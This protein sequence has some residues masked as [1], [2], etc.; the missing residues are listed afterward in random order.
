[1]GGEFAWLVEELVA[2]H[3]AIEQRALIVQI[4]LGRL[5]GRARASATVEHT[6]LH[7]PVQVRCRGIVRR[8]LGGGGTRVAVKV[9]HPSAHR[10]VVGQSDLAR[11]DRSSSYLDVPEDRISLARGEQCK[12]GATGDG[13]SV[14]VD[15]G[16][17]GTKPSTVLAHVDRQ[18]VEFTTVAIRAWPR[19]TTRPS[20]AID[21]SGVTIGTEFV[22]KAREGDIAF[23]PSVVESFYVKLEFARQ[24]VLV[25]QKAQFAAA[26]VL[27]MPF[28]GN[29]ERLQW[30]CVSC[31]RG[32]VT[33]RHPVFQGNRVE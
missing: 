14:F 21:G 32:V 33:S 20:H 3:F 1:M 27:D 16:T 30:P 7:V 15:R 9:R 29:P 12:P 6:V 10:R 5:G 22:D 28:V 25:E 23:G 26:N 8:L 2:D 11:N 19:N 13:S 31:S 18:P 17:V 4:T 24:R